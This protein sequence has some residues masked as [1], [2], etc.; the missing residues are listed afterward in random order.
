MLETGAN[1]TVKIPNRRKTIGKLT[2]V[3]GTTRNTSSAM[4]AS[5]LFGT[6]LPTLSSPASVT[7][8]EMLRVGRVIY[9]NC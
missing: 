7:Q 5:E 4:L 3:F 8:V 6:F 1:K 2:S 9:P